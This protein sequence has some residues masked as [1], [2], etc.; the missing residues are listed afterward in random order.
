MKEFLL[1]L[2]TNFLVI[3]KDPSGYEKGPCI[4]REEELLLNYGVTLYCKLAIDL[5]QYEKLLLPNTK[6]RLKLIR[7]RPK[8]YM[9]SYKPHVS[10]RVPDCSLFTRRWCRFT[11]RVVVNEVYHQTIK[12]QLTH[13]PAC[14]DF[15]ETIARTFIIPS[16]QNQFIQGNVFNNAPIRRIA[17]AMNT[18]SA[19]TGHLQ[20]SR[21]HYRK[22]TAG[23][24]NCSRGGGGESCCLNW[25]NQQI[26]SLCY[27][28][29]G[30]ELQRRN[31][32][33]T[34]WFHYR[35]LCACI[36]SHL[37]LRCWWKCSLSW[38]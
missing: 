10:L 24:E 12:Y 30:N 3:L 7:A 35:S 23:A 1:V 25:Y 5:F 2:D 38:T 33:V 11:R 19:F 29:E 21:F 17:I 14:Y 36:R 16:G 20:E 18:N 26:Y 32:C 22:L 6:I 28:N 4:D 37:T 31:S 8:F 15:M 9:I 13:Q 27:N 34:E